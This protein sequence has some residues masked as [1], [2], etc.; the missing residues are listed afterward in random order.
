MRD[1]FISN[2]FEP[3]VFCDM[4][5]FLT[6][7]DHTQYCHT[8]DW[9]LCKLTCSK[10]HFIYKCHVCGERIL[11]CLPAYCQKCC[12][13]YCEVHSIKFYHESCKK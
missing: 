5:T 9:H 7:K 13:M 11:N 6:L 10:L 4:C 8:C 1:I 2:M 12:K 3:R